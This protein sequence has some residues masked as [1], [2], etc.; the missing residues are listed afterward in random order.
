M[1]KAKKPT[2]MIPNP[3]ALGQLDVVYVDVDDIFPN[4][5]NPNRQS[6]EDFDLLL[7]SMRADGFTQPVIVD[8][9][10]NEIVDGE[11][12]WRGAQVL[13]D[14]P[15]IGHIF[16][17]IPVVYVEMTQEQRRIA[18]LRHNRARGSE[19]ITLAAELLRDLEARGA[20]DDIIEGLN[21]APEELEQI[22]KDSP[23]PESASSPEVL[24]AIALN[25]DDR[26]GIAD[27]TRAAETRIAQTIKSQETAT[28]A[29]ER[30]IY[31]VDFTFVAEESSVV[32][33]VLGTHPAMKLLDICRDEL[34][35]RAVPA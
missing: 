12:R 32:K 25:P 31:R 26:S 29:R 22:L 10:V 19:D 9:T 2:K 7:Q 11:H 35:R 24:D 17:K 8:R 30:D 3:I 4:S 6:T 1:A 33:A 23:L 14:D 5:Y 21:M 27:A 34:A 28:I 13:R 16:K 20:H 15:E 18:T